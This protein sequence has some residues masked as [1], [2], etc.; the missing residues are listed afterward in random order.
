MTHWDDALLGAA[1]V[2][3]ALGII[4]GALYKTYRLAQR[5]EGAIGVDSDGH[6]LADNVR[7]ATTALTG[8]DTRV[9]SLERALNPPDDTPLTKRVDQLET[10]VVDIQTHVD[11]VGTKVD[12]LTDLLRGDITDRRR[13]T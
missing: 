12:T 8:L 13:R 9:A 4:A 2:V 11:Q 5:I 7:A 10:D 6:T 3:V 1:A